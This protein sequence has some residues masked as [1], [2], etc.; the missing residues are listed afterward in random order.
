MKKLLL[1]SLAL[2]SFMFTACGRNVSS[3]DKH[4]SPSVSSS[5]PTNSPS[6]STTPNVPNTSS[7][8]STGILPSISDSI[9]RMMS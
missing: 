1:A 2:G 4:T 7:N 3:P 8:N 6:I 5:R 9:S